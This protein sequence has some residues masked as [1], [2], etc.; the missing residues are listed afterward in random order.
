VNTIVLVDLTNFT[1]P[2]IFLDVF[3]HTLP[4]EIKL[5]MVDCFV[6]SKVARGRVRMDVVQKLGLKW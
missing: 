4:V 5:S 1:L 2:N 3:A 6:I